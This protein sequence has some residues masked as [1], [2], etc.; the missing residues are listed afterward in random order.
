MTN[1]RGHETAAKQVLRGRLS[2]PQGLQVV[3]TQPYCTYSTAGLQGARALA[4]RA[5]MGLTRLPLEVGR[6]V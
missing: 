3:S 5:E 2:G 6:L 1:Q 4:G